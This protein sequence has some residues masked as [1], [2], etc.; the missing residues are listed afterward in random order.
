MNDNTQN[1][2]V[3]STQPQGTAIITA[4]QLNSIGIEL[5]ADQ[6]QALI[7]HTEETINQRIGEEVVDSLDDDQLQ[8]LVAMQEADTPAEQVEAWIIER[9]TDYQEIVEDN[10]TIVLGELAENADKL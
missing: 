9:V 5:P 6:M 4:E 1:P 7:E 8:E 3:N 2:T 10:T